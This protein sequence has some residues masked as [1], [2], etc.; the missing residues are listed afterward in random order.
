MKRVSI[1]FVCMGNIC[2]SPLAEGVFAHIARESGLADRFKID[3]AGTGGW[4]QGKQP[5][6]RSIA[7]AR[8]HGID[9][10]GQRA[11]RVRLEDFEEFDLV[12][13]MD[14]AN[15]A[16]LRAMAPGAGNIMLFGDTALQTGEDIP[17][18]YFGGPEGFELIYT[19]LLTGCIALVD[20]F[21]ADQASLSGNTSSVR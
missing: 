20:K 21:G 11:R 12:L 19:R 14:R 18:P 13:A 6:R 2:R 10:T 3:S 1:L 16:E 5:D 7:I 17:D 9:I 8:A 15:I 4:H